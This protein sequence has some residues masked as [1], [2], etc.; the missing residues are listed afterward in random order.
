MRARRF[1][2]GA[3]A[4]VALSSL[5]AAC[6]DDDDDDV[7]T[8]DTEAEAEADD[9]EDGA[10]A[11]ADLATYCD[12][13]FEIETVGEPDVDFETAS[14]EEIAAA[15]KAFATDEL[16]PLAEEIVAV[17]PE[18]N[19]ANVDLLY[20][21]VQELA[22]T[23]DFEAAFNDEVEDAGNASHEFDLENCDWNAVD[24]TATNY[25]FDGID[26]EISAGATSFEL[27]NEG[28]ELH[29]LVILRKNDDTTETWDELLALPEEEAR[30][31]T[32]FLGQTSAA[33]GEEYAYAA[34]DLTAGEY[35]AV[36]FIP[37]GSVDEETEADG[38]PHFTQGMKQEFT[39]S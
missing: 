5:L 18:E 7:A 3:L 12:K 32:T 37:V 27:T 23:G 31:K 33:P 9:S 38:P 14:E 21:A 24:V 30:S 19:K 11:D 8:D 34:V 17:T 36:C 26:A 2:A 39:V 1:V 20:G 22:E 6:G 16:L 28:T 15:A 4:A 35:A 10:A 29:E 13:T 25:K